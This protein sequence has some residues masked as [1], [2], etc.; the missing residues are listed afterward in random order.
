MASLTWAHR[1]RATWTALGVIVASTIAFF[2]ACS[3]NTNPEPNPNLTTS[4]SSGGD[5]GSGVGGAGAGGDGTGGGAGG[6][7]GAGCL[8]P[9][10]CWLCTPTNDGQFLNHCTD[11]Q[12]SFFDD[13][14]RLPLYNGGN[15]PPLP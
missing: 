14:A 6:Q 12:C 3:D 5:G 10:D 4:S 13:A 11:A 1:P 9:N 15:L 7:G 8:G 2:G